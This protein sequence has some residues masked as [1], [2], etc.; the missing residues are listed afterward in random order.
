MR[1]SWPLPRR[2]WLP[3]SPRKLTYPNSPPPL[4]RPASLTQMTLSLFS[5]Q[6]VSGVMAKKGT[7]EGCAWIPWAPRSKAVTMAQLSSRARAKTACWWSQ[8]RSST[9]KPLCLP[10]PAQAEE[11]EVPAADSVLGQEV[12]AVASGLDQCWLARWSRRVTQTRTKNFPRP[13]SRS[14][15]RPGSTN[16]I[17]IEPAN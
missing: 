8:S 9:T 2:C 13:S 4:P 11:V 3:K 14:W 17:G 12:A 7:A 6:P 10:N 15:P 16:W 1:V 5:K